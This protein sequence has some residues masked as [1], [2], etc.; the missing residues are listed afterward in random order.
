MPGAVGYRIL[1]KLKGAGSYSG[2][3]WAKLTT[4]YYVQCVL[5]TVKKKCHAMRGRLPDPCKTERCWILFRKDPAQM[6]HWLFLF[7]REMNH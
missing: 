4:D 7:F 2:R 1:A 3:I 6:K 5:Q